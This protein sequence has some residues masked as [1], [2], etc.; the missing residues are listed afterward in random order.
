MTGDPEPS[1]EDRSMNKFLNVVLFFSCIS[2]NVFAVVVGGYSLQNNYGGLY[3]N[4]DRVVTY[5]NHQN[6]GNVAV[7]IDGNGSSLIPEFFAQSFLPNINALFMLDKEFQ[8]HTAV[9]YTVQMIQAKIKERKLVGSC[10]FGGFILTPRLAKSDRGLLTFYAGCPVL[11]VGVSGAL[12]NY[13]TQYAQAKLFDHTGGIFMT[14]IPDDL[15]FC[16]TG[17][18]GFWKAF[19]QDQVIHMVRGFI[20]NKKNPI[21]ICRKFCELARTRGIQDD[22]SCAILINDKVYKKTELQSKEPQ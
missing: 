21:T 20:Y 7:V 15:L 16:F 18:S 4:R 22:I 2:G 11:V 12:I 14:K 9:N 8:L 10:S 1:I 19:N 5:S 6:I 3:N 13:G 17:T